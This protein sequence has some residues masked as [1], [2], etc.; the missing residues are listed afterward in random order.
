MGFSYV[1]RVFQCSGSHFLLNGLAFK[2]SSLIA[3]GVPTAMEDLSSCLYLM[4]S[5][6]EDYV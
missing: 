1:I 4:V 5:I 3:F 6:F 2:L